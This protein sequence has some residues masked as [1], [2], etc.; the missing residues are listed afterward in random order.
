MEG[1]EED[2]VTHDAMGR[3]QGRKPPAQTLAKTT[4]DI[5]FASRH[6]GVLNQVCLVLT[7]E[8]MSPHSQL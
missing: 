3:H 4:N 5:R 1:N 2:S 7:S 8:I 6:V